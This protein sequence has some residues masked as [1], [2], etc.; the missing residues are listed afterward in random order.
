MS[1]TEI[2]SGWDIITTNPIERCINSYKRMIA[3][4]EAWKHGID[5]Q[6]CYRVLCTMEYYKMFGNEA[7]RHSSGRGSKA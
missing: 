7:V 5:V 1:S 4:I 6:T 3:I 2:K